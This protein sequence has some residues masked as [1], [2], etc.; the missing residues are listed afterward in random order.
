MFSDPKHNLEQFMIGE[1]TKLVEFGAGSGHYALEAGKM[2]GESGKVFAIDVQPALLERIK[3]LAK[4]NN[5]NNIDTIT[6]DLEQK[7]GSKLKD[8]SCDAGIVANVLFQIE[9]KG[10]F[11]EEVAR[12]IRSG[13]KVLVVDW[14]DSFGGLGPHPKD[15]VSTDAVQRLFEERGFSVEKNIYAGDHHFG[16]IMRK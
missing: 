12:V 16:I 6:A 1:G 3:T 8:G 10:S 13:G 7:G 15:I 2:V 11:T 9:D 4:E 14:T 5:L